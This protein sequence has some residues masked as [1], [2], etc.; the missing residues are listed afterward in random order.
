MRFQT[1]INSFSDFD[2]I[3]ADFGHSFSFDIRNGLAPT[4]VF[5]PIDFDLG[6]FDFNASF[7]QIVFGQEGTG[8]LDNTIPGDVTTTASVSVGGQVSD[9]LDFSGDQDWFSITLVAGQTYDISLLGTGDTPLD[10]PLVRI[11]DSSG[12]QLLQNDD[13]INGTVRNSLLTYTAADSGTFYISAQAFATETG[14]YTLSVTETGDTSTS[15]VVGDASTNTVAVMNGSISGNIENA[16]DTDWFT[17]TLTAGQR[18]LISQDGT[19]SGALGDA[20]LRLYDADGNQVDSNDDSG[21]GLNARMAYVATTSGTYYVSA[22]SAQGVSNGTGAYALTIK[23]VPELV[24]RSVTDVAHFLTDEF[25]TRRAYGVTEITYNVTELSTGAQALA[26]RALQ[27]WADVT[28]LTFTAVTTGGNIVFTDNINA[29]TAGNPTGQNANNGN[30]IDNNTGFIIS[31]ALNVSSNWN[32]GNLNVDSY[33][34]QTFLHEIGHSLG[35]GHG[36]KL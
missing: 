31:S 13:I 15:D 8:S 11:L 20:F 22:G 14:G 18:Y 35:L 4:S 12:A 32:S 27:A 10:D 19:G 17:I 29:A 3:D 1:W 34:Y 33:T 6:D 23:E 7:D 16:T 26:I 5:A 25:S 24:E 36:G 2:Y 21:S 28:P 30:S 9:V